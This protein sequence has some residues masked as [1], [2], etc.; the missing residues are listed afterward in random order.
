VVW[1]GCQEV[2]DGL[3]RRRTGD[4]IRQ[5]TNRLSLAPDD[6]ES[7][8]NVLVHAGPSGSFAIFQRM[9][10]PLTIVKPK[11]GGLTGG[12]Q[13][14]QRE[15]MVRVAFQLDGPTVAILHQDAAAGL[16]GAAS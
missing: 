4:G 1:E 13:T 15:G 8:P 14:S 6:V 10:Q 12:T 5:K 9:L 3:A 2:R 16:A 11:D 7:R